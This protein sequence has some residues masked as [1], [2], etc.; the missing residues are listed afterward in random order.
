MSILC[1]YEYLGILPVASSLISCFSLASA[2]YFPG[3]PTE[4]SVDS[5]STFSLFFTSWEDM[6]SALLASLPASS[7]LTIKSEKTKCKV[8]N[9]YYE[10]VSTGY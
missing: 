1:S 3:E 10:F 2:A 8:Y 9:F 5:L 6:V 4:S 7:L